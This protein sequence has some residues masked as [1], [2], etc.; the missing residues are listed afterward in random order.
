MSRSRGPSTFGRWDSYA[1]PSASQRASRPDKRLCRDRLRRVRI[2]PHLRPT[3]RGDS[4]SVAQRGIGLGPRVEK[5]PAGAGGKC[6]RA[7]G[8]RLARRSTA[9]DSGEA[10]SGRP[11]RATAWEHPQRPGIRWHVRRTRASGCEPDG[12]RFDSWVSRCRRRGRRQH[13]SH[14]V[15]GRGLGN[16]T[17]VAPRVASSDRV[18]LPGGP[19]D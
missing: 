13:G 7:F 19:R 14:A 4:R 2:P 16:T 3:E 12:A 10:T 8:N 11:A 18:Q 9:R 1:G 17:G 15:C 5:S 6:A